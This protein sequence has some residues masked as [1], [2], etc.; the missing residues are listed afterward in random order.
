[1]CTKEFLICMQAIYCIISEK[2]MEKVTD[3]PKKEH[4][5]N[6]LFDFVT[7]SPPGV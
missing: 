6:S 1:M 4:N 3:S 7:F 5:L 2:C